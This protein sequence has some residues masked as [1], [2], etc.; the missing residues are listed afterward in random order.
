MLVR[1]AAFEGL[2]HAPTWPGFAYLL[3]RLLK[4]IYLPWNSVYNPG[5]TR[6]LVAAVDESEASLRAVEWCANNFAHED[7]QLEIVYVLPLRS[8]YGEN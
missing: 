8:E 7:D 6:V 2:L 5:M 4:L 3:L 1:H